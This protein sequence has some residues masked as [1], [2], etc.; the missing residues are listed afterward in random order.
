[1][2]SA[3]VRFLAA[4]ACCAALITAGCDGDDLSTPK[5]AAQTFASAMESGDVE[6]AKRAST[7]ADPKMIETMAKAMGSMKK[8]KEAAISKFGDEGKRITSD[9]GDLDLTRKV[10]EAEEKIEGD[11]ATLTTKGDMGT[12]MKLKKID[13]SWKV[14]GSEMAGP[15]AGMGIAMFEAAAKAADELANEISAGKYKTADEAKTAM[16]QKMMGGM[17]DQP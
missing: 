17:M 3:P 5:G 16:T 9:S 10:N 14:D 2:R 12:P 11:T 6:T 13:G 15:A 7:G 8:L 1:M 4:L